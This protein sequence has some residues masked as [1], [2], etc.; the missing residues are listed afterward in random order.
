[1]FIYLC[2]YICICIYTYIHIHICTCIYTCVYIHVYI[3]I[4]IETCNYIC[5]KKARSFREKN[6]P[7]LNVPQNYFPVKFSAVTFFWQESLIDV[8]FITL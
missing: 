4:Y 7:F 2:M 3:Y 8:A 1:M 5:V 6:V